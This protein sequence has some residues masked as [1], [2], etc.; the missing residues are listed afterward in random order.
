MDFLHRTYLGFLMGRHQIAT[1]RLR[2]AN[3]ESRLAK[4]ISETRQS[5]INH[6]LHY[7]I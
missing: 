2:L 4:W 6:D 5:I 3:A 7:K 1:T